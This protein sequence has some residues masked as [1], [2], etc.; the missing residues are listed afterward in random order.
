MRS[1]Q[2]STRVSHSGHGAG[3]HAD[4]GSSSFWT[5]LGDRTGARGS[6]PNFGGGRHRGSGGRSGPCHTGGRRT[7]A[8]RWDPHVEQSHPGPAGAAGGRRGPPGAAFRQD[9]H[10]TDGGGHGARSPGVPCAALLDQVGPVVG[11][12][13]H[14][15]PRRPS[16]PPASLA[17]AAGRC[18]TPLLRPAA[19]LDGLVRHLGPGGAIPLR[20]DRGGDRAPRLVGRPPARRSDRRVGCHVAGGD[21]TAT[22]PRPACTRWWYC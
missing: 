14:R 16:P 18:S 17:V 1:M 3:Y 8:G 10:R 7:G 20:C 4:H 19:L 5:F 2:D 15:E 6:P 21:L 13:P 9:R 22:T 12:G 11:R